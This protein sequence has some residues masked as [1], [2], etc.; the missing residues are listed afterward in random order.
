MKHEQEGRI[1]PRPDDYPERARHLRGLNDAELAER[2]WSLADQ[3]VGPL[4]ELARTHT[5][6]S[7]E[8]SVLLRMGFSSLEAQDLVTRAGEA[9]LM[10]HG[11]GHLVW[12]LA[13]SKG[14]T[15]RQ[16]GLELAKGRHWEEVLGWYGRT[17][18]RG[19]DPSN[20][21]NH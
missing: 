14:L 4:I 6:P 10:G 7:I 5:S 12:R 21:T 9:G 15:V 16:A 18:T 20:P 19:V 1:G 8:R 3:V 13:R 11:V 17:Q 2:F